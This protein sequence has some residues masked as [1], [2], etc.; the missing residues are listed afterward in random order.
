MKG[1]TPVISIILIL[2]ITIVLVGLAFTIFSGV[3]ETTTE[4]TTEGLTHEISQLGEIFSIVST[5]DN[6]VYIRNKGSET[7]TG[8]VFFV[9]NQVK[10]VSHNCPSGIE[11][12]Q[13]CGFTIND[14]STGTHDLKVE[15]ARLSQEKSIVVETVVTTT[16]STTTTTTIPSCDTKEII[17]GTIG[18]VIPF[19]G[20]SYNAMR[21]QTLFLQT[22]IGQAGYIDKIY[23]QK[24]HA[25]TGTFDNFRIYLCHTSL[26]TLGITFDSNC[27][28][29][30]VEVMN[31]PSITLTGAA[32]EWSE[33][34]VDN[35]FTYNNVDNLVVEM[36]WNGDDGVG[37]G[38]YNSASGG[39]T[40]YTP[41]DT[42]TTGTLSSRAYNF[43]AEICY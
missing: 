22:E 12:E 40:V 2:S 9:D 13:V 37:V 15:G 41:D 19:W 43:R 31:V 20:D 14:V 29:P 32:E 27:D 4:P 16:T 11:P 25:Y 28:S 17:K 33:F 38:Y 24:S 8:L 6:V 18:T 36:R 23:L 35:T 39:S 5:K 30:A 1:I 7:L 3:I 26:S 10:T 34:D 21:F 42:A